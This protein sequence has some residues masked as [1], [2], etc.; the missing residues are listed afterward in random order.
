MKLLPN[1]LTIFRLILIPIYLLFFYSSLKYNLE[2]AIAIF[3]LASITDI[4]DG[5]IARKFDA[6][7]KIGQLLDPLVDKL[8][9]LTVIFTLSL[10]GYIKM[11]VFWIILGK[12][13]LMI[14]S[15]SIL[16]LSKTK[17]I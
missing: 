17:I 16:F 14:L 8:M 1:I 10:A 6:V 7:T 9:Q 13:V 2:I 4:I 12:E 11:W 5:V 3:L 15:G